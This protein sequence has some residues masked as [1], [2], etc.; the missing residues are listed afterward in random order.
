MW[1]ESGMP[2]GA[3]GWGTKCVP[4]LFIFVF[5]FFDLNLSFQCFPLT[6]VAADAMPILASPLH[7]NGVELKYLV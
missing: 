4:T 7:L 1:L 6:R 2:H 5:V 3:S